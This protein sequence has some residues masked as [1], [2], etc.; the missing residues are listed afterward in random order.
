MK[1]ELNKGQQVFVEL[2]NSEHGGE[3]WDFGECLWSPVYCFVKGIESTN[4]SWKIMETV[5]PGDL[6]I[7]SLKTSLGQQFTGVSIVR[8]SQIVTNTEPV[9]AGCFRGHKSY[10]KFQLQNYSGFKKQLPIKDFLVNKESELRKL[11]HYNSFFDRNLECAQKYLSLVPVE[12]FDQLLDFFKSNSV[13]LFDNIDISEDNDIPVE[14]I[15]KGGSANPAKI[16]MEVTRTVRDTKMVKEMKK[17]YSNRCQICGKKITLPNGKEYS[18]GHHLKKLGGVH[19]GPDTSDNII[20]LCPYHHTEFDYG[21]IAIEPDDK[22]IKH[23]DASNEFNNKE[24]KYSRGDLSK[25]YLKYH[26]EMIFNIK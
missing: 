14:G 11:K 5:N 22:L 24:L 13:T 20:V 8:T 21:A 9:L 3:G 7:H 16:T 10:Y 23:I 15:N 26:Y 4:K 18:E 2:T 19:K 17:K 6:I 12:I 25:E 1:F